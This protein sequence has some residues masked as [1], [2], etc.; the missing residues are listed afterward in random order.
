MRSLT[1]SDIA[2]TERPVESLDLNDAQDRGYLIWSA[3]WAGGA[4]RLI[5]EDQQWT[6]IS[7]MKWITQ[8]GFQRDYAGGGS[9]AEQSQAE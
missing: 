3:G 8:L 9:R 2:A 7:L 1:A 5:K 4:L 6:A